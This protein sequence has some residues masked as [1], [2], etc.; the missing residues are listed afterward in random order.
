MK[1]IF[2]DLDGTLLPQDLDVYIKDYFGYLV[3]FMTPYGFDPK[4]LP[5]SVW[6][7][8][9]AMVVNDGSCTNQERFWQVFEQEEDRKSVV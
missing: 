7:G 8:V 1:T 2:F 6:K 5:V 3:K 4:R 9:N